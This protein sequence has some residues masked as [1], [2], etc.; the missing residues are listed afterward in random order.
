[1]ARNHQLNS[2]I[3]AILIAIAFCWSLTTCNPASQTTYRTSPDD[4]LILISLDG[5]RWD[6]IDRT[7]TPNLDFLIESGAHAEALIPIFP[8]KTF[9]NHYTIITGLFA[10]NHGIVAN[11]MY[12][13]VFDA[14][15]S[16]GNREAVR[17]GRWYGGEPLWVT[18]EKQGL[19][20]ACYFWPG[21]E[22]EIG[23]ER[24]T[25][26]VA[27]DDDTPNSVRVSSILEFIDLTGENQPAFYTLY[28]SDM[29]DA[30]HEFG[31]DSA[32]I[33]PGIR[34][35]DHRSASHRSPR[36]KYS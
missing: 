23:G 1:M 20:T 8:S 6:Y 19:V 15:F 18:A 16:L 5:F 24:P 30:G 11:T 28:F 3:S 27:Y 34:E 32:G 22:A 10:E 26:W 21:S 33:L 9:P 17:D 25:C 13:P 2:F 4:L 29:D 12:D 7:N 35:V 14:P 36:K 31:P